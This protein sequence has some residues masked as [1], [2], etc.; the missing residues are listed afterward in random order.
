MAAAPEATATPGVM[1]AATVTVAAT[2][3]LAAAT[4]AAAGP[5]QGS[6]PR[7]GLESDAGRA[8]QRQC[9]HH[10]GRWT[11][12]P[13]RRWSACLSVPAPAPPMTE[14]D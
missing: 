6:R 8:R 14:A 3:T 5:W 4:A 11:Q 2:V 12:A 13:C 10:R 9:T 1:P 7:A